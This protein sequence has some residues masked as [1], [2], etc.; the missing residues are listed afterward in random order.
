M[1][2]SGR[3]ALLAL[4]IGTAAS[5]ALAQS[6]DALPAFA[7]VAILYGDDFVSGVS[8]MFRPAVSA[9]RLFWIL[10]G[11]KDRVRSPQ[12]KAETA[13]ETGSL[14]FALKGRPTDRWLGFDKAQHAAFSF[15]WTL[16]SQYTLVNKFDLSERR[17]LPFSVGSGV[18]LGLSK[19]LYDGSTA[20]RNS[21]S[22]RDLAADA[23]G[24]A[25]AVGLILL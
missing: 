6:T 2:W 7:P 22:Y 11:P 12:I 10:D 4:L 15:L 16:S 24:I 5:P 8:P 25:L 9:E 19:E 3:Y 18:L 17:A 14:R 13:S 21:F 20:P 1:W 23:F